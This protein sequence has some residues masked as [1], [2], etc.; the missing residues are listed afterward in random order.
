MRNDGRHSTIHCQGDAVGDG[1]SNDDFRAMH[2][3]KGDSRAQRAGYRTVRFSK[4]SVHDQV[5]RSGSIEGRLPYDS[6][7]NF[8][9]FFA[10]LCALD[11]PNAPIRPLYSI[12]NMCAPGFTIRLLTERLGVRIPPEGPNPFI[13]TYLQKATFRY[14]SNFA[15]LRRTSP[16]SGHQKSSTL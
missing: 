9:E 2:S 1:F 15:E 12:E 3:L 16:N 6:F 13:L 8:A 14:P 4:R 11:A 7:F 10:E 5:S